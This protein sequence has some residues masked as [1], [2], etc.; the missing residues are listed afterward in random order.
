MRRGN[1][2]FCQFSNS[3]GG[4]GGGNRRCD[5]NF[6][7]QSR[8]NCE[9]RTRGQSCTWVRRGNTSFCR[10]V[11]YYDES[12]DFSSAEDEYDFEESADSSSED[13]YDI[14]ME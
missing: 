9:N 4:G 13:E 10:T 11:R 6:A 12:A 3:G 7:N 1:T 14:D 8:N 2:S 5:S